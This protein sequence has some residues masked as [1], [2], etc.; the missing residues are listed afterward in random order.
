MHF[1]DFLSFF[2]S[3][4]IFVF[5]EHIFLFLLNKQHRGDEKKIGVKVEIETSF[6]VI[7]IFVVTD[8]GES[9]NKGVK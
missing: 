9:G 4:Y 1:L 7:A 3:I 5:M 8:A 2:S 6:E